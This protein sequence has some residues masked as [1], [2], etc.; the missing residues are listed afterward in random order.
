MSEQLDALHYNS[1]FL[2]ASVG[3]SYWQCCCAALTIYLL[4]IAARGVVKAAAQCEMLTVKWL[5]VV[6]EKGPERV[7]IAALHLIQSSKESA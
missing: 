7:V 1:V 2:V 3:L 6:D 5:A 4:L